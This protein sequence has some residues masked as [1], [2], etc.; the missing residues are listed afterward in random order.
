MSTITVETLIREAKLAQRNGSLT[1][2]GKS[3]G[4]TPDAVELLNVSM[5]FWAVDVEYN[6]KLTTWLLQTTAMTLSGCM[7]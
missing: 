7:P 4:V 1:G 5:L 6:I 2:G 3:V